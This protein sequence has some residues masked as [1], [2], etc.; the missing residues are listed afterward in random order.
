[1]HT[2][3]LVHQSFL[4]LLQKAHEE[5]QAFLLPPMGR[6]LRLRLLH[7]IALLP[8]SCSRLLPHHRCNI[9]ITCNARGLVSTLQVS[10]TPKQD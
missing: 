4:Q 10:S 5:V 6:Q 8:P 9:M 7:S 2:Q 1:M 3:Y